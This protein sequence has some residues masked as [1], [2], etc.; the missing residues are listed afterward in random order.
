MD[1]LSGI[2]TVLDQIPIE[3][4]PTFVS[5]LFP[6]LMS[7]TFLITLL[8]NFLRAQLARNVLYFDC[9]R[10]SFFIGSLGS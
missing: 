8:V 1:I 6:Y 10:S 7:Y 3:I 9:K 4:S 2:V 5:F